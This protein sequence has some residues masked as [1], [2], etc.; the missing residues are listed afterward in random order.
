MGNQESQQQH[1]LPNGHRPGPASTSRSP[2]K[3]RA[4][5]LRGRSKD[6]GPYAPPGPAGSESRPAGGRAARPGRASSRK[7]APAPVTADANAESWRGSSAADLD[8]EPSTVNGFA[9][10]EG[11]AGGSRSTLNSGSEHSGEATVTTLSSSRGALFRAHQQRSSPK[12]LFRKDTRDRN[13]V[14]VEFHVDTPGE[15]SAAAA[16]AMSGP[17]A[18]AQRREKR[19]FYLRENG[20]VPDLL[21]SRRGYRQP[22][23]PSSGCPKEGASQGGGTD[24]CGSQAGA[25]SQGG[26][27]GSPVWKPLGLRSVPDVSSRRVAAPPREATCHRDLSKSLGLIIGRGEEE[28]DNPGAGAANGY[29]GYASQTLPRL[30]P[31]RTPAAGVSWADLEIGDPKPIGYVGS[32]DRRKTKKV[33]VEVQVEGSDGADSGIARTTDSELPCDPSPLPPDLGWPCDPGFQPLTIQRS[34]TWCHP[35]DSQHGSESH[36]A[37]DDAEQTSVY[38]NY[39]HGWRSGGVG[40]TRAPFA[41]L[42][43]GD[44]MAGG[45]GAGGSGVGG[46]VGGGGSSSADGSEDPRDPTG[47][48]SLGSAAL[49]LDSTARLSAAQFQVRKAGWL[50][51]KHLFC[52]KGKKIE[53]ALRR[54]WRR[55]WVALRGCSLLFSEAAGQT[56]SEQDPEPKRSLAV[57]GALVQ[58][59]PEH[60]KRDFI[61]CLSNAHGEVFCFQA[62]SQIELENWVTAVHS[63][64]AWALAGRS[65]RGG[66][67]ASGSGIGVDPAQALTSEVR[68]LEHRIDLDEKM[69][70]MAE[71]QLLTVSEP[72]S[73]KAILAQVSQWERNLERYSVD[74]FRLRC[75]LASLQGRE[76]P[77]PKLVLAYV[78]RPVKHA[79]HRLGM[80]SASSFHALVCARE[81]T[82]FRKRTFSRGLSKKKSVFASLRGLDGSGKKPGKERPRAS[83][84]FRDD[85]VTSQISYGANAEA[86]DDAEDWA[87]GEPSERRSGCS[88]SLDGALCR[89]DLG[90]WEEVSLPGD[91]GGGGGG[92]TVVSILVLP[93]Y[94]NHDVLLT[95][96][97]KKGLD[98]SRHTLCM[99]SEDG[100]AFYPDPDD[101]ILHEFYSKIE[102]QAKGDASPSAVD[103]AGSCGDDAVDGACLGRPPDGGAT[104]QASVETAA[105][106]CRSAMEPAEVAARPLSRQLTEADKLR[107]VIL[108]LV[109]TERS[110]VKDLCTLQDI[111]VEPLQKEAFLS[112]DQLEALF[113]TLRELVIFQKEFLQTLEQGLSLAPDFETLEQPAHFR[114]VLFSLGG[115]F[116]YYSDHF[117]LYSAYCASHPKAQKLLETAKRDP[118][119]GAFLDER[120]PRRQHSSTLE[121]YLIKPIQRVLKY[122]LLLRELVSLTDADS[123][124]NYHLTEAL[125]AMNKVA[126]HINEMQKVYEEY[127]AVFDQLVVEQTGAHKEVTELS[128]GDLVMNAP[129]LW[130]NP[131]PAAVSRSKK[132][133][134]AH[135]FV[136]KKAVVLICKE[137]SKHK[138]KEEPDPFKFKYMI[139]QTSLQVRTGTDTDSE[140]GAEWELV[141]VKSETEGRPETV[142]RVC[143]SDAEWRERMVRVVRAVLREGS[144][145]RLCKAASVPAKSPGYLPFGGRRLSALKARRLRA[146]A[147]ARR[148]SR[149]ASDGLC[150]DDPDDDFNGS[151]SGIGESGGRVGAAGGGGGGGGGGSGGGGRGPSWRRTRG[152]VGRAHAIEFRSEPELAARSSRPRREDGGSVRETDI[153]SSDED[154]D[155]DDRRGRGG[156][157]GGGGGGAGELCGGRSTAKSVEILAMSDDRYAV[158]TEPGRLA[159]QVHER[160]VSPARSDGAAPALRPLRQQ[161]IIFD[162]VGGHDEGGGGVGGG[163]GGVGGGGRVGPRGSPLR[164]NA[165]DQSLNSL[166]SEM[167]IYEG[168]S[169]SDTE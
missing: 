47:S 122:P 162:A 69:R 11:G 150:C 6:Y 104:S 27:P 89:H 52:R 53:P 79:M 90:T 40:V 45:G 73:R 118:A 63:A 132:W 100:N 77:N 99:R 117:K 109:E 126:S 143:C 152:S 33:P 29:E 165:S 130:L 48:E 107:K 138:K 161:K 98:P 144:R 128:M 26:G 125:R 156:V 87:D 17:A 97:K 103:G 55:Y 142:F 169:G 114:R 93:L 56:G 35:Q 1:G 86:R 155:D 153:L 32:L 51:A 50:R 139:P 81:E 96:C 16:G 70:K 74:A 92:G 62:E 164:R 145:Q 123:E 59:L 167:G 14:R 65:C 148:L 21:V 119:F 151:A 43:D 64:C 41:S 46:G 39:M 72:K 44:A 67:G 30:K 71:L 101:C 57:E 163:G 140:A 28:N 18:A 159:S 110:Y 116:L 9:T 149:Y 2:T 157:G 158:A 76:P 24:G 34:A 82:G 13:G 8:S 80:F 88:P 166:L 15:E 124:E 121:S 146:G 105:V 112:P 5:S 31:G 19:E 78:S 66:R 22:L 20:R 4:L 7:A 49:L 168:L 42:A 95:A 147:D 91:G 83:Q 133:P 60:P 134:E 115:S 129:V 127:G 154:D 38:E 111:Y 25:S 10:D 106:F 108:E 141:H 137:H 102:V 23:R 68:D 75:Y 61:F 54:K 12:I 136:F 3:S 36:R 37:P 85:G 131:H 84:I 120:N 135:L 94:R 113:G 58:A 160:S